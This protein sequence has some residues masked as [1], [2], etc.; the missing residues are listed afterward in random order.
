MNQKMVVA[1]AAQEPNVGR[2]LLKHKPQLSKPV[3]VPTLLPRSQSKAAPV[4]PHIGIL[5]RVDTTR[6]NDAQTKTAADTT[7]TPDGMEERLQELEEEVLNL[8]ME[9]IVKDREIRK[10][11]SENEQLCRTK[12]QLSSKPRRRV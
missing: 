3:M 6:K 2:G 4:A 10:L 12:N 8:K 7:S 1:R 11:E 5:Y 9:N